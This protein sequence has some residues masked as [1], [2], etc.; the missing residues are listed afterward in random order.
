MFFILLQYIN[1]VITIAINFEVK[2]KYI[3]QFGIILTVSFIGEILS[4]FV[5]V[6]IPASI[7]GLIIMFGLLQFKIFPCTAVKETSQFLIDIMPLMFIPAAVGILS[8]GNVLKP[9][10]LPLIVITVIS[11]IITMVVSG[12]VTQIVIKYLNHSKQKN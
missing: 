5:P 4:R 6:P 12:H 2:M 3:K 7:Y 9:L 11:T 8:L 1:S 10:L